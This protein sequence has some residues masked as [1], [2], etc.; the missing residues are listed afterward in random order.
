MVVR[1]RFAPSPTGFLHVGN[2]RTA[3]YS[4]LI[5]KQSG[6][7]FILRIEDTDQKR[8]VEGGIENIL[9]SLYWAGIVPDEGVMMDAEEKIV[10]GG[11]NGP[12][13]QSERLGI[14]KKY[15]DELLNNGHAY[16]CFCSAER[17]A[18][19][20]DRQQKNKLPTGYDGH[21]RDIDIGEAQKKVAAG[22]PYVIRVK[23]PR[24][25]E[26]VL[27]DLI[28][29]EV[30][31]RNELVDDQIIMKSDGFPTYHLAVVVDDYLMKITHVVRGEDWLPSTPKHT[32]LYEYLG[33][34]PPRY[35]HLPL[36]LNADKSKLSKRQGDVAV[37]DYIKK[38]YL[39]E[40][41]L[42]FVA[43]LG[44]NPGTEREILSLDELVKE[45]KIEKINKSGAVFNLKKLDWYNQQYIRKLNDGEFVKRAMP[46]LENDEIIKSNIKNKKSKIK[47]LT[48]I[49]NLEKE[50]VTTLGELPEAVRF[51]FKLPDYPAE[52]LIWKKS[53]PD[54]IKK[55]LPEL[56]KYLNT[57][58]VQGWNRDEL[59]RG[60][61]EWVKERGYNNGSV[62]W[63]LRV[64]LSGQ[65]NSPG[66]FEMAEV[67][68]KEESLKRLNAALEKFQ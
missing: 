58:S 52:L 16:Y 19:V 43:F 9:K 61:G 54:E 26:T 45:F 25:G 57:K 13:I 22:E 53:T 34:N 2:F 20:K 56:A 4:Y 8:S 28:R 6:G 68:R 49:L 65:Q 12:Y 33:W 51:M 39:P 62:L 36:L 32:Q 63:P 50:R 7:K 38:G 29:G 17:L 11:D 1:T 66:P 31:F 42:N 60:I 35:A 41:M 18:E 48:G 21:C 64:A 47:N 30:R 55:I 14:Y 3:L 37:E 5:A 59:E 24:K 67:L 15:A 40:A 44:W 27:N 10:Q 23:M 46:F